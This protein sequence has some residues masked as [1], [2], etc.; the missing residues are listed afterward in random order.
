MNAKLLRYFV[1]S[2]LF[3]LTSFVGVEK[4][5][6]FLAL[7][8]DKG[9]ICAPNGCY[10]A[11]RSPLELTILNPLRGS[12]RDRQPTFSWFPVEGATRY[13]VSLKSGGRLLWQKA[14]IAGTE[15]AYPQGEDELDFDRD[16]DLIVEANDPDTTKGKVRF[17]TMNRE[18]LQGIEREIQSI[19]DRGLNP[20]ETT[21]ELAKFYQDKDLISDAIALLREAVENNTTS[22]PIY[23]EL[24]Q[25]YLKQ[26]ESPRLAKPAYEKALQLAQALLIKDLVLQAEAQIGLARVE[27]VPKNEDWE[28]G[29]NHLKNAYNNY[30]TVGD[31][32]LEA[33]Q[34]AHFLGE[35]YYRQENLN[36]AIQWYRIALKSYENLG[37][38]ELA[39]AIE[40]ILDELRDYL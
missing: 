31:R 36:Y 27:F 28:E 3:T 24:G 37:E 19:R 29:I 26:V 20:D 25:L 7:A 34:V 8:E 38:R 4:N 17:R 32:E 1:V 16:Y 9:I 40:E 12:I 5:T 30:T 21:L 22:I 2:M 10:T 35:I 18:E 15:L 39:I 14:N 33:A 23:L 6:R 13:T 11:P